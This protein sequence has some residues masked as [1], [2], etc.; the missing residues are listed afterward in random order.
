MIRQLIEKGTLQGVRK[1]L[2][3]GTCLCEAGAPAN[4]LFYLLQG[5]AHIV[6]AQNTRVG[7]LKANT[8]LGLADYNK[9]RYSQMITVS[10]DSEVMVLAREELEKALLLSA[11]LRLYMIQQLSRQGILH[12]S[13]YE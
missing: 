1:H 6:S 3:A 4:T 2:K 9:E 11:P 5:S 13:A 12:A 7:E 10:E 8:L